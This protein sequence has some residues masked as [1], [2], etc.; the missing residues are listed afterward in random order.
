LK[1]SPKV[2]ATTNPEPNTCVDLCCDCDTI[3]SLAQQFAMRQLLTH[4][5][6]DPH[7]P[8]YRQGD[9]Q[10]TSALA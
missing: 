10:L 7:L 6:V 1:E 5:P 3:W 8:D 2:T 4:A 9:P